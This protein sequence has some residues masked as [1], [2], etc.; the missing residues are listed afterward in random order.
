MWVHSQWGC[1][2]GSSSLSALP[3]SLQDSPELR[4]CWSWLQ[5][6]ARPSLANLYNWRYKDLGD[7]PYV[8]S[9]PAFLRANAGFAYDFQFV[10]VGDHMGRG[11]SEP[12]PYFY[13]VCI[14]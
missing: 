6:R 5:G 4:M 11:E 14:L 7:L 3:T 9:A 13:Q 10:D 2:T 1:P 8:K 12:V